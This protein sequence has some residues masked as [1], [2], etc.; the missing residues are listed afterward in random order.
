V[1][2]IIPKG[3][4]PQLFFFFFFFFVCSLFCTFFL[5]FAKVQRRTRK[6]EE[7][8]RKRKE[9]IIKAGTIR[10]TQTRDCVIKRSKVTRYNSTGKMLEIIVVV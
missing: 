5:F 8:R 6:E 9:L 3:R 4:D 2:S 10:S 1:L 7:G